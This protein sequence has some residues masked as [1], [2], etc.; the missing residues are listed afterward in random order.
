VHEGGIATPFIVQWPK[1]IAA[2]GEVRHNPG[3]LIDIVPTLLELAGAKAPESVE[4]KPVPSAPGRSLVPAF[5]KDG[6]VA[7]DYL[8]WLHEANRALRVGDWKIVAAGKDAAWELY[9]LRTDR[10]ESKNL[11]ADQ[12]ERVREMAGLWEKRTAEFRELALMDMPAGAAAQPAG[13][14]RK[15]QPGSAD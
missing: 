14:G 3:H 13:K 7:H 5:A 12:P 1:G 9:D 2:R 15:K 8:W 11:A 10:A 4:G 6:T